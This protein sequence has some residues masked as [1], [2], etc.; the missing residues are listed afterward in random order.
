ME[1]T[2]LML[3]EGANRLRAVR[4]S[5]HRLNGESRRVRDD[6]ML[7]KGTALMRFA[8]SPPSILF[9]RMRLNSDCSHA[10]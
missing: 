2:E 6:G 1:R 3:V 5:R 8:L 7:W 4:V 9:F 10:T